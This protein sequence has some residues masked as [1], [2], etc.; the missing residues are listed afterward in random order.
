MVKKRWVAASW[1]GQGSIEEVSHDGASPQVSYWAH[2]L[3]AT[4]V[5]CVEGCV[6]SRS[7]AVNCTVQLA[8]VYENS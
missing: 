3:S 4:F 1:T 7:N 2:T 6:T 5:H 8:K